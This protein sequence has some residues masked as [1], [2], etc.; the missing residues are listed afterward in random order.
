MRTYTVD[1]YLNF[2]NRMIDNKSKSMKMWSYY[3][4]GFTKGEGDDAKKIN[5]K[6]H[7]ECF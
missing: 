3:A 1:T 4:V 7:P 2:K 5:R 6:E